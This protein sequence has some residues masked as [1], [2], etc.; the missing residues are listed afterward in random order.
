[1]SSSEGKV[2]IHAVMSY[3]S[4]WQFLAGELEK[5]ITSDEINNEPENHS[6]ISIFCN[7]NFL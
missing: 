7:D 6:S 5:K 4:V 1:L 2:T 3:F